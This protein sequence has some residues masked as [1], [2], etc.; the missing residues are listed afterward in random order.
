MGLLAQALTQT[1]TRL[2]GDSTSDGLCVYQELVEVRGHPRC[3]CL[4][5]MALIPH[6]PPPFFLKILFY[7]IYVNTLLHPSGTPE[8]GIRSQYR[9]L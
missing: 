4:L 1:Y 7:F 9:W 8:E 2:Q 6:G 3:Q 5:S